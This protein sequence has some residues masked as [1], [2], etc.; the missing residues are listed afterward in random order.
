[1]GSRKEITFRG[2][3][4]SGI[5]GI[6]KLYEKNIIAAL[7]K[8]IAVDKFIATCATVIYSDDKLKQCEPR[9]ILGAVLHASIVG[10][11]LDKTMKEAC[12][13][14]YGGECQFQLMYK[15][16]MKL[17]KRNNANTDNPIEFMHADVVREKDKLKNSIGTNTHFDHQVYPGPENPGDMYCAYL[18][19][20]FARGEKFKIMSK[21][22][23]ED[24]RNQFSRGY[25]YD[26]SSGKSTSGWT[27][28]PAEMWIKT[29]IINGCKQLDLELEAS[30]VLATDNSII[31]IDAYKHGKIDLS[32]TTPEL[33]VE[34]IPD[35]PEKSALDEHIAAKLDQTNEVKQPP[36]KKAK[37]EEP[38]KVAK[39]PEK[40]ADNDNESQTAKEERFIKDN[41]ALSYDILRQRYL[42]LKK[43]GRNIPVKV[44][45]NDQSKFVDELKDF[46]G[47]VPTS[48]KEIFDIS[49]I[50]ALRLIYRLQNVRLNK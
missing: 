6:I 13:I 45:F 9:S 50:E 17:A 14:A 47:T 5:Q 35:E 37:K 32:E 38:V 44:F 16:A 18:Y 41:V 26:K 48:F 28:R 19:V 23:I 31:P 7:P 22:D 15:G 27:T 11:S 21:W 4:I 29:V 43:E 46:N 3:N 10:L 2:Q 12:L 42:D 33:K 24:V 8:N 30:R 49:K 25:K 36:K 39:E 1:M 20:K 40:P 34:Q